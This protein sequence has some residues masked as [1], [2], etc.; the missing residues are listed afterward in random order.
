MQSKKEKIASFDPNG[1]GD[2]SA[3]I[4]GLPFTTEESELI[5]IPVPWDVTASY[6]SGACNG[7]EGVLKNS[8]QTNL[9]NHICPDA[10]KAGI[11]ME[12]IPQHIF[13]L[14]N[15]LEQK[16]FTYR[17]FLQNGGDLKNSPEMLN[18][19]DEINKASAY[20]TNEVEFLSEKVLS[21]GKSVGLLGGD[22][23]TPLGLIKALASKHNDFGVLQIDAHG[24]LCYSYEGLEQSHASIMYNVLSLKEVKKL[25]QV[26]VR[27]FS[28]E[29]NQRMQDHRGRINVFYDYNIKKSLYEGSTWRSICEKIVSNLPRKVYISFDID[30][31]EP[32]NCPSTGTPVP[33]GLTYDQ[34]MYLLDLLVEK[35]KTVIGFDLVEVVPDENNDLDTII[36]ARVLF[37]LC[38]LVI[39]TNNLVK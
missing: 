29:E 13:D 12:E 9:Y 37:K 32:S 22:H 11:A 16:V 33:G 39:K 18:L 3:N 15:K 10:W 30:G 20:V 34:A 5:I 25:V 27:E 35:K 17:Q 4:F 24:D 19:R 8:P 26:G 38:T 6:K 21:A 28:H 23:S 7:P 36:A 31:L 2:T 1:V 14:N